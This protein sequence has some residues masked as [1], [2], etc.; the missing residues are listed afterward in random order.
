MIRVSSE[1]HCVSVSWYP[2]ESLI[3]GKP[4]MNFHRGIAEASFMFREPGEWYV[5]RVK[6][7]PATERSKGIGSLMLTRLKEALVERGCTRLIVEPGGYN[8]DHASQLRFYERQGF[9]PWSESENAYIWT[10]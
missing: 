3:D 6:V 1:T 7:E 2:D 4:A 9:R 5:N 8:A 10:P